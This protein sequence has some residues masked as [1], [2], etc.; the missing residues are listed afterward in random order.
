MSPVA[1]GDCLVVVSIARIERHITIARSGPWPLTLNMIR[2]VESATYTIKIRRTDGTLIDGVVSHDK[3]RND[4][5]LFLKYGD[6]TLVGQA[7]DYWDAFREI[8]RQLAKQ[9][10]VPLCYGASRNVW[11]SGMSRDMAAGLKA[12]K[13]MLG[14]PGGQLVDIFSTGP[15]IDPVGLAEQ[16]EFHVQWFNS[17]EKRGRITNTRF[18]GQRGL[19]GWLKKLFH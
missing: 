19:L 14:I 5:R 10:L 7:N 15:D 11:P 8:R 4:A 2:P 3:F 12:Y 9:G 18:P 17:I 6:E 13:V 1:E 16:E